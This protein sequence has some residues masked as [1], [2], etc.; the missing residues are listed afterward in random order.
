MRFPSFANLLRAA[1]VAAALLLGARPAAAQTRGTVELVVT[2]SETDAPLAGARVRVMGD[3][4]SQSLE[5]YRL[6]IHELD[7]GSH[8]LMV[9]MLGHRPLEPKVELA[10]GQVLELEVV[11]DSDAIPMPEIT[12]RAEP[13]ADGGN[14]VSR[15]MT[16]RRGT[17]IFISREQIRRSHAA[18]I[19]DLLGKVPGVRV[20]YGSGGAVASV[21]GG[22]SGPLGHHCIAQ[23]Y[24]D[25]VRLDTPAVNI[26]AVQELESVEVYLRVV[27]PEYNPGDA[28]C[29]VIV[30]TTRTQ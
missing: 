5:Q 11:L 4:P 27:P 10:P 2:D 17:G 6:Q 15:A 30:L 7:A 9:E 1:V 19:S 28:G 8:V 20:V 23:V 24:L 13:V 18:R 29:G 12:A 26:V 16:R 21:P 22:Q 3:A 25:G 14:A